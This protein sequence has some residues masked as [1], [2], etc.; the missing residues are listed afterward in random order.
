MNLSASKVGQ[1]PLNRLLAKPACRPGQAAYRT[2]VVVAAGKSIAE[3]EK[4]LQ[5]EILFKPFEEVKD[6]LA[7][8]EDTNLGDGGNSD[9]FARVFY[10]REAEY[11]VNEQINIEMN[12][13]YIYHAIYNY[14]SR[15][16]VALPGLAKYFLDESHAERE[17]AQ[18]LMDFQARR[19]GRTKLA[20]LTA[21]ESEYGH[22][23]KGDAL[24]A[25][26]I[27]L[28]LEKLNFQKLRDLHEVADKSNDAQMADFVEGMLAEQ[29]S[30]VKE[31]ADYVAQLRRIG[32]GHGVWHF[33]QALQANQ[34]SVVTPSA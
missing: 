9:S 22:P 28:S 6:E 20:H 2:N 1:L 33:D 14:F 32:P 21:P 10:S 29:A 19:G 13:S 5:T 34:S 4:S 3:K 17:H 31:V 18:M 11:A 8:V 12:M 23:E 25:M 30:D 27:G 15:D 26:E 16:N 7:Q 24:H